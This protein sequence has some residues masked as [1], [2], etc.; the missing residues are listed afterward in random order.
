MALPSRKKNAPASPSDLDHPSACHTSCNA[1]DR[2]IRANGYRIVSRPQQ[3]EPIW[4]RNGETW[5]ESE[6]LQYLP[7]NDVMDAQMEED[8][9]REGF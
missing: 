8:L 3:G 2:L 7:C 4:G 5:S 1:L 6:V 9:Y